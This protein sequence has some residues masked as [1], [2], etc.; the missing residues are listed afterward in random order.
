MD[1]DQ[2]IVKE[3]KGNIETQEVFLDKMAQA[4]ERDLGLSEHRL[5]IKIKEKIIHAFFGVFTILAILLLSKTLYWQGVQGKGLYAMSQSNK[6]KINLVQAPRGIIYDKNFKKLLSN[7]PAFDVTCDKRSLA[8]SQENSLKEIQELSQILGGN[9]EDLSR[10]I[11][12]S[13]Q[14]EILVVENINQENLLVL[15][16]RITDF[17]N[18]QIKKNTVRNYPMGSIFSHVLGYVGKVSKEDLGN[19]DLYT[20]SD[21]IGKTGL[22]KS[23]DEILRGKAG[24]IEV[25]KNALGVKKQEKFLSEPE[26]GANLVLNISADLQKKVYDS[27]EQSIGKVGAKK[28]AAVAIDPRS[29]AVLALVSYPAYDNNIFSRNISS[30]DFIKL[31]QDSSQPFFNRAISA[32]YPVGSTIKPF[33]ALAALQEKIISPQKFIDDKGYISII[34]QYNSNIVYT[35]RGLKPHGLVDMKKAVAVSSNIYFFTIGGGYGDQ[36]GLGPTKIKKYLGLFGWEDKTGID[37]P[38]EFKGFVPDETWKRKFKNEPWWDGDTYNLSI[39]QSDLQVT[40][41]QVAIAYSAIA[42][43][44]KIYKPQV[45]QK[46]ISGPK[47]NSTTVKKFKPEII[48]QNFISPENIQIVRE[49]MLDGVQKPYGSSYMLSTLPFL[50]AGKTGTVQT[51]KSGFFNSWSSTFAPYNNPEIVFVVTIEGVEGFQ[52]AA[53]P[54]ARDVLRY[55]FQASEGEKY[56]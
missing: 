4:R 26:D 11:D 20:V 48:R 23:Y 2:Y 46:I 54:V 18:C 37:L 50:V 45:V 25:V 10:Q 49:G 36:R 15:E 24:Q 34:N 27:L 35:F 3:Q 21:N 8:I 40:P 53:L 56:E 22:E 14:P 13:N 43:G 33:L 47:E 52:S 16:E 44:G 17:P 30:Q 31:Q 41:L 19:N 55:Y 32:K 38:G 39:G 42:N 51:N 7:A 29:G 1:L 9:F 28:G 12:Q 6:G 5:E